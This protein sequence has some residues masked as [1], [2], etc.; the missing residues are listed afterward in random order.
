MIGPDLGTWGQFSPHNIPKVNKKGARAKFPQ[1]KRMRMLE[2]FTGCTDHKNL[3]YVRTATP[4]T[5]ERPLTVYKPDSENIKSAA[6]S[7]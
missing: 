2:A 4:F 1:W 5:A 3:K 7:C 6:S